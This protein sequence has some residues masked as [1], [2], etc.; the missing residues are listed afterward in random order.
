MSFGDHFFLVMHQISCPLSLSSLKTVQA[1]C[2]LMHMSVHMC[3]SHDVPG[4][5]CFL[6]VIPPIWLLQSFHLSDPW[7]SEDIPP[8][9]E[10]SKASHSLHIVHLWVSVLVTIYC[11]RI[12]IDDGWTRCWPMTIAEVL[13]VI[14]LLCSYGRT[15]MFG[16]SLGPWP[17]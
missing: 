1:L 10:F 11:K 4:R 5:C 9:T 2:L 6:C 13:G 3:I 15:T 8:R 17:I 12:V 14:A 16:L 7:C